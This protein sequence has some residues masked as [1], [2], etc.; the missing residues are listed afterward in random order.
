[1]NIL[2]LD[3]ST[4]IAS[5]AINKNDAIFMAESSA[6]NSHIEEL[7]THVSD[8]LLAA[9]LKISEL[10]A[11]VIGSGPGS[12]TGLRIGYAYAFGLASALK[13]PLIKQSSFLAS[14]QHYKQQADI[15]LT[16]ADARRSEIFLEIFSSQNSKL[17]SLQKCSIVKLSELKNISEG[18]TAQNKK[19]LIIGTITELLSDDLVVFKPVNIAA[20][21][22]SDFNPLIIP[23]FSYTGLAQLAPDYLRAVSAL[24]I[25]ER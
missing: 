11:I 13:I 16:I 8:L 7:D 23:D 21:L 4:S 17:D 14:C 25:S 12:F 19:V 24:K 5:L 9:D 20:G 3:T 18:F 15:F 22:M 1:M 2:Y 6:P 10:S